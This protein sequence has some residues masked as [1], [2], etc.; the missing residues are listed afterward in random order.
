MLPGMLWKMKTFITHVNTTQ[1]QDQSQVDSDR[2]NSY[3]EESFYWLTRPT[4]YGIPCLVL[5]GVL[6]LGTYD[7]LY[8]CNSRIILQVQKTF[9]IKF[10]F[11]CTAGGLRCNYSSFDDCISKKYVHCLAG[12]DRCCKE[13]FLHH[14]IASGETVWQRMHDC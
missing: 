1:L 3:V 9:L 14:Q 12:L 5:R 6:L 13:N 11:L 10:I 4:P 2:E 8:C 7:F